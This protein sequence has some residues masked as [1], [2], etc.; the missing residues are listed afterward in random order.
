MVQAKNGNLVL[1]VWAVG[2]ILFASLFFGLGQPAPVENEYPTAAEIAALIV[3]P[4]A[5]DY[6]SDLDEIL[7]QVDTRTDVS[8]SDKNAAKDYFEDELSDRDFKDLV[9]DVLGMDD[10]DFDVDDVDVKEREVTTA[11]EDDNEDGNF[12]VQYFYRVEFQDKDANDG[13]VL[14]IVVSGEVFDLYDE[15]NDQDIEYSAEEVS[16]S[17]EFD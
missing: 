10:D 11:S 3:I 15:E 7:D 4:N 1:S 5:T 17:F 14:Y 12:L 16:R 8:R 13:E 9:A 2:L 6:S